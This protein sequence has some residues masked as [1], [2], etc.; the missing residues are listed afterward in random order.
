MA[1]K[2]KTRSKGKPRS[3]TGAPRPTPV[4]VKPPFFLRRWV[5]V[6]LSFA[7]GIIAMVA[8]TWATNGV[9]AEHRTHD[10][11]ARGI[12]ARRAVAHWQG[13]VSSALTSLGFSDQT[14]SVASLT[15]LATLADAVSKGQTPAGAATQAS[16]VEKSLKSAVKAL[17]TLSA[18]TIRNQGL[19]EFDASSLLDSRLAMLQAFQGSQQ[20]AGLLR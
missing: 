3:G 2:G 1:I 9:R 16:T 20:A 19:N 15:Q 14:R 17:D 8:F 6:S 13:S 18:D 7:A 12:T 11:A 10:A 4:A 5:Q